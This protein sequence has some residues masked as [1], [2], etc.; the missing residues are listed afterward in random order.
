[1]EN[2]EKKLQFVYAE[3]C[4]KCGQKWSYAILSYLP[5]KFEEKRSCNCDVMVKQVIERY[6]LAYPSLEGKLNHKNEPR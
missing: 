3:P 1:M 4:P 6:E 5:E 2:F